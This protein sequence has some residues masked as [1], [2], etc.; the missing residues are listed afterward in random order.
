[1]STT[2][3]VIHDFAYQRFVETEEKQFRLKVKDKRA[4][5]DHDNPFVTHQRTA[6]SVSINK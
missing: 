4:D 2:S 5:H 3:P 6:G 1:M